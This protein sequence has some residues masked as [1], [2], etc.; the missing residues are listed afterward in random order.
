MY[1][2]CREEERMDIHVFSLAVLWRALTAAVALSF[3]FGTAQVVAP[4]TVIAVWLSIAFGWAGFITLC[5]AIVFF[6]HAV[7]KH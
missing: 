6:V 2:K 5:A 4:G 3:A 1:S 7:E